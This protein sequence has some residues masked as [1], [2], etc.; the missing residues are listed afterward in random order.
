METS[1][2]GQGRTMIWSRTIPGDTMADLIFCLAS[3][4]LQLSL[5]ERLAQRGIVSVT[6]SARKGIFDGQH[7]EDCTPL[8]NPT[9]KDDLTTS[10]GLA[11]ASW[12]ATRERAPGRACC[13]RE[14][15]HRRGLWR[16]C[17]ARLGPWCGQTCCCGT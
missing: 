12:V 8:F 4:R 16:G 3:L 5:E 2:T 10:A 1:S 17:A 14:R 11:S 9:F 13:G 7:E 6:A 15:L